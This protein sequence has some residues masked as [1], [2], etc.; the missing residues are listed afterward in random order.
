MLPEYLSVRVFIQFRHT[1]SVFIRF[2][3]LGDYVHGD[4]G[5]IEIRAYSGC[6]RD[7]RI[8]Q[9]LADHHHGD[10]L[11]RQPVCLQVLRHV[12]ED[13][14]DRVDYDILLAHEFQIYPVDLGAYLHIPVHARRGDQVFELQGRIRAE[15]IEIWGGA[16]KI[17]FRIPGELPVFFKALIVYLFYPLYDLEKAGP[18]RNAEGF[19]ARGDRKTDGLF[20]PAEIRHDEVR[21]ERVETPVLALDRGVKGF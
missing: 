16:G 3:V 17:G 4:L 12:D 2:H 15:R 6:G 21:S 5:Q 14:V 20:R 8:V 7:A 1:D 10:L 13:L 19:E 11:R 9:D 18:S